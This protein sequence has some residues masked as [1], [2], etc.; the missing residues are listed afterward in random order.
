MKTF[1]FFQNEWEITQN[2]EN[3]KKS[4]ALAFKSLWATAV[5]KARPIKYG[6]LA[7]FLQKTFPDIDIHG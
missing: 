5:A 3:L 6:Y 2:C 4:R 1:S 7:I